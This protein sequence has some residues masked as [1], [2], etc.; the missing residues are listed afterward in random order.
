MDWIQQDQGPHSC[1]CLD[2]TSTE[3]RW[4]MIIKNVLCGSAWHG[5]H[6]CVGTTSYVHWR[7]SLWWDNQSNKT[8]RSL[9]KAPSE[10]NRIWWQCLAV[11]TLKVV[12]LSWQYRNLMGVVTLCKI[13]ISREGMAGGYP[14]IYNLRQFNWL[15]SCVL[16]LM[17]LLIMFMSFNCQKSQIINLKIN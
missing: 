13:L 5:S 15:V 1:L 12:T 10:K 4:S 11:Y 17:H 8:L 7:L 14:M 2:Q 16:L 9:Q 6:L 3:R